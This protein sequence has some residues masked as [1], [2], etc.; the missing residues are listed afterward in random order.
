MRLY[1]RDTGRD[2][3]RHRFDR[4]AVERIEA[5]IGL[6]HLKYPNMPEYNKDVAVY[7]V[8]LTLLEF[9]RERGAVHPREV[10]NHFSHGSVK[11]YWGGSS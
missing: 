4:A 5:A 1:R 9:V 2:P 3:V 11:N 7:L 8:G 10:D 6:C